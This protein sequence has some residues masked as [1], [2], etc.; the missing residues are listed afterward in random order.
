MPAPIAA[1]AADCHLSRT[2]WVD[3][4]DI[5]DDS[6]HSFKQIVDWLVGKPYAMPLFLPGDLFDKNVQDDAYVLSFFIKQMQRLKEAGIPVYQIQGQHEMTRRVPWADLGGCEHINKRTVYLAQHHIYGLDFQPAD[7]L[8]DALS[9]IPPDTDILV[10]HQV[11]KELMGGVGNPEG[12]F[13]QVPKSVKWIVTGDYHKHFQKQFDFGADGVRNVVST[14]ST[15]IRSLKEEPEKGFFVLMSD[16][17]FQSVPLST[18]P[19]VYDR[20]M[21]PTEL[22]NLRHRSFPQH[23]LKPIW[24]VEYLYDIDGARDYLKSIVGERAHLFDKPIGMPKS[25]ETVEN[26]QE[27]VDIFDA[28]KLETGDDTLLYE[29]CASLLSASDDNLEQA[30]ERLIE[31]LKERDWDALG[32]NNENQ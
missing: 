14:G 23:E 6:L 16:N 20:V 32:I 27:I 17:T 12:S 3:R 31:K 26:R 11:W 2:I 4:P 8:A 13:V 5:A 22:G 24:R 7:R 19:V 21:T 29:S 30:I 25:E 9:A 18:R 15:H 1:F 10:C 28:L